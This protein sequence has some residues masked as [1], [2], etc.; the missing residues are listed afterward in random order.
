MYDYSK[1]LDK[2][3][4]CVHILNYDGAA[5]L[6][7]LCERVESASERYRFSYRS[8]DQREIPDLDLEQ[9]SHRLLIIVCDGPFSREIAD[10]ALRWLNIYSVIS[11]AFRYDTD[12]EMFS[13]IPPIEHYKQKSNDRIN[14]LRPIQN[15]EGTWSVPTDKLVDN[16]IC[17]SVRIK[18]RPLR[19]CGEPIELPESA[20]KFFQYAEYLYTNYGLYHRSA[21]DGY[22]ACR[23]EDGKPGFYITAT[24]S[25]KNPLDPKRIVHVE[26]YE[27]DTNTVSYRG[28]FLPSSDSVEAAM[29]FAHCGEVMSIIHTH[30]SDKFTRHPDYSDR[31]LVGRLPY[32]E[33]ELGSALVAAVRKVND[34]FV[35]MEDHGEVFASRSLTESPSLVAE[36]RRFEQQPR[37]HVESIAS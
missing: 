8:V 26:H 32:G 21:S 28:A 1:P 29:L 14:F 12:Q 7:D 36:L 15:A 35:I 22:F 3:E 33:Q 19:L 9:Y 20:A 11:I 16:S 31:I 25:Y 6:N 10:E 17:D 34:G 27:E 23:C 30:A 5:E 18:Y 4:A 37:K 2:S 13:Y 24:K